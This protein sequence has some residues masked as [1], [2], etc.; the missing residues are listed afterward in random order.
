M[1][2][3]SGSDAVQTLSVLFQEECQDTCKGVL[4]GCKSRSLLWRLV[5]VGLAFNTESVPEHG[6]DVTSSVLREKAG[7]R[8][9]NQM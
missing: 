4:L 6:M 3:G 8:Q 5:C 2:T 9:E 7:E 1:C